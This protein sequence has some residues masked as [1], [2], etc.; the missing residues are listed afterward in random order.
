MEFT[1]CNCR[2]KE[3]G[4]GEGLS[5]PLTGLC[6]AKGELC[7]RAGRNKQG[8]FSQNFCRICLN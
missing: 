3:R 7:I 6:S 5:V 8:N 2:R 4:H 1:S